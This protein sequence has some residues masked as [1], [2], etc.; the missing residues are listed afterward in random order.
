VWI[1][2]LEGV[3]SPEEA[4]LLR[5]HSLLIPATARAQLEDEDEFYVQ[6]GAWGP[7]R[8]RINVQP[9]KSFFC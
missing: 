1:V 9:L 8:Q 4:R 2:K 7:E 5:G 3:E 6:V